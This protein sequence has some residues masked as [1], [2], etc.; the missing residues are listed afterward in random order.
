MYFFQDCLPDSVPPPIHIKSTKA[1]EQEDSDSN[2]DL[3]CNDNEERLPSIQ[4]NSKSK[5]KVQGIPCQS[6]FFHAVTKE[7]LSTFRT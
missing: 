6:V 4:Q 7:A 1:M 2:S 3:S 5:E